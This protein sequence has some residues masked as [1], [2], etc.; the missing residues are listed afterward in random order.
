MLFQSV[1]ER[2][3]Y[4]FLNVGKNNFVKGEIIR[5]LQTLCFEHSILVFK[6]L[7]LVLFPRHLFF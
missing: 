6:K 4:I 5:L 2:K 1:I 3:K 7:S